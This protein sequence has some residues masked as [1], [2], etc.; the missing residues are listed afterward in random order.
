MSFASQEKSAAEK[1]ELMLH[2][3][4]ELTAQF[5]SRPAIF[6]MRRAASLLTKIKP[7]LMHY[8]GLW[9]RRFGNSRR[10]LR[11]LTIR[12]LSNVFRWRTRLK[13]FAI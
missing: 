1:L 5:K 8:L 12:N 9:E 13:L 11:Q 6:W 7:I 10:R 2:A 4:E 3:R